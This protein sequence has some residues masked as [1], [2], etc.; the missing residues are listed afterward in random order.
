MWKSPLE[1]LSGPLG[2]KHGAQGVCDIHLIDLECREFIEKIQH[3]TAN[4]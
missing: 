1:S 3:S 4:P 2:L